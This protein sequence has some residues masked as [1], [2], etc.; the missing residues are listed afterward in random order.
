[1]IGPPWNAVA[2]A[3]SKNIQ[4]SAPPTIRIGSKKFTEGYLLSEIMAQLIEAQTALKVERKFG[5][6]GTAVCFEALKN[7]SIDLYPEYTGTALEVLLHGRGILDF[8]GLKRI[9]LK[10]FQLDWLEPFGF[11]NTYAIA[12]SKKQMTGTVARISDLRPHPEYRYGLSHEFMERGDG[13][14]ALSQIY[15]LAP[16]EVMGLDHGLAYESIAAGKVDVIDAYSTDAKIKKFG[17]RLLEDDRRFFPKYLAVPLVRSDFLRRHPEARDVLNLLAGKISEEKMQRLNAAAELGGK[18]FAQAAA[19]FLAEEG[20]IPKRKRAVS[21]GIDSLIL[22]HLFLV[23]VSVGLATIIGFPAGILIS[24]RRKTA[25]VV[26]AVAGIAQTIPGIALL[27]FMI[28][29]LGIGTIPAIAALFIYGLLPIVRN[30]CVGIR[31]I[32]PLL[33]ETADGL[34][35]TKWQRL[36]TVEIPLA[37]RFIMAGIRISAVTNIGTATLAAF[38]GAGGLGEPIVTGLALNDMRI[39]FRGAIPAALLAIAAEIFFEGLEKWITPRGL[40]SY[41]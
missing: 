28:P 39:V 38:I 37:A 36:R 27:V 14:P 17:L 32:S 40:R 26:L 7:G 30:S 25:Q 10:E 4:L 23:L 31:E 20:L 15:L 24:R 8:Q 33:L 29:I 13:W 1:M 9:F 11:N 3:S 2:R 22:E 41:G 16:R 12:V 5:L 34:G 19:D 35:L 18:S 21:R 6:G